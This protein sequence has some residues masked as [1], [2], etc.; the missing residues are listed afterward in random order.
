MGP[1]V[2]PRLR[3]DQIRRAGTYLADGR[4]LYY[5]LDAEQSQVLLENCRCPDEAAQWW[6]VAEVIRRLR[7]VRRSA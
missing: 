2:D 3:P 5:V 4:R 7:L 6:T 1:A